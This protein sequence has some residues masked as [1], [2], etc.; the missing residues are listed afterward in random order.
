MELRVD[1]I[2]SDEPITLAEA[3]LHLRVEGTAEDTLITG[4]ISA[5]RQRCEGECKRAL[6]PQRRIALL[7]AFPCEV[8]L[9]PN[10]TGI[11]SV[12]YRDAGGAVQT[13]ASTAYRLVDERTLVPVSAWPA[14]DTVRVTFTCGAYAGTSADSS[15]PAALKSWMLLQLGAMYAQREAVSAGQLYEPPGRFVDGLLDPYRSY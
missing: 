2:L 8:G 10:V 11:T 5:A 9:G 6:I 12:T 13:L 4:L 3:K 15:V 14:G 7:D 1:A